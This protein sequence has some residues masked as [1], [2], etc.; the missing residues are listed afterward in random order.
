MRRLQ[1]VITALVLIAGYGAPA[2]AQVAASFENLAIAATA[3]GLASAT[4]E[5]GGAATGAVTSCTGQVESAGIRVRLDGTAPT[6]AIGLQLF[7]GD[8]IH[9]RNVHDIGAFKAIRTT[10]SSGRVQ[11]VCATNTVQLESEFARA[12]AVGVTSLTAAELSYL[13]GKNIVV[14]GDSTPKIAAGQLSNVTA[15]DTVVTGLTTVVSCVAVLEDDPIVAD[16]VATCVIGDQAGTPAAG[17][18]I[19]KTWKTLGGTPAAATTFTKKV[20]WVA[21]GT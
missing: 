7:V 10:G 3:V 20:N 18:I 17:S 8:V 5:P 11:F 12:A 9:L 1:H 6:A 13:Q 14:S 16:E 2:R 19:I 4:K 21:Y 15:V